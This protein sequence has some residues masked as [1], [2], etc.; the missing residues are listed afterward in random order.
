MFLINIKSKIALKFL[1]N[2]ESIF[3][4][5]TLFYQPFEH[6][7]S[8]NSYIFFNIFVQLNF[9]NVKLRTLLLSWPIFFLFFDQ[10]YF[11]NLKGEKPR[12]RPMRSAYYINKLLLQSMQIHL[13][14]WS[15]GKKQKLKKDDRILISKRNSMEILWFD[16]R[17]DGSDESQWI[18]SKPDLC[19]AKVNGVS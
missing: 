12:L 10:P 1:N 18:W 2:I 7:F 19:K 16:N 15:I 11:I 8:H 3:V 9:R 5:T 17:D 4:N 14:P 6:I 13:T